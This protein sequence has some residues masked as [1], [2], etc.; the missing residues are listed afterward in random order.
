VDLGGIFSKTFFVWRRR[1]N[2]GLESRVGGFVLCKAI[3][4]NQEEALHL[5]GLFYFFVLERT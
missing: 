4:L 3:P 1:K 5:F 2:L